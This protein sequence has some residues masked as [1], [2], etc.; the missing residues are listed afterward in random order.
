MTVNKESGFHQFN[1]N[2]LDQ[3]HGDSCHVLKT[4]QPKIHSEPYKCKRHFYIHLYA[5]ALAF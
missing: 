2:I 1:V 5:V 4:I 3:G